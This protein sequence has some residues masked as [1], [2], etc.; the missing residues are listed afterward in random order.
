[1]KIRFYK[2]GELN[3]SSYVKLPLRSSALINNKNDD[4][5]CLNWSILA[6]LQ[7]CNKNHPKLVS[8]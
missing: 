2:T 7:P 8:T 6:K 1:M 4:K 5:S 3:G